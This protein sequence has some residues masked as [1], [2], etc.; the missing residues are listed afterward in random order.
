LDERIFEQIKNIEMAH[1]VWRKLEE[2][3]EGTQAVKGAKTYILKEKFASFKMNE[4][5]SVPKMF[6]MLQ[7]L[8]NDLKAFGEE[9]KDKNFSHNLLRCIPSRFDM[10]VM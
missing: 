6:R 10:L 9:V 8:V 1:E 4:D 2:S 7:V 3:F 5:E